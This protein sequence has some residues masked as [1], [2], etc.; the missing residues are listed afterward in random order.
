[1]QS[2]YAETLRLRV[3]VLITRA[4]D[5]SDFQLGEWT[6]QKGE[7]IGMSSRTAALNHQLWNAGTSHDPHPLDEFWANRFL[8]LPGDTSSGPLRDGRSHQVRNENSTSD[9]LAA[10]STSEPKFSIDG[11]AG[12]WIPFGGGQRMCPGRHFAKQEIIGTF[13]ML[14][15]MFDIELQMPK[16]WAPVMDMRYFPLGGLPIKGAVGF[17]IRTRKPFEAAVSAEKM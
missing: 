2:V 15:D 12:G 17:R 8:V 13:A 9:S 11:L 7:M 1:M 5:F 4:P 10:Q 14:L 16:G 6:L 3:A